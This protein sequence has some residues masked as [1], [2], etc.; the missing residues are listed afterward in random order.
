MSDKVKVLFDDLKDVI[1]ALK[2]PEV[3]T[4]EDY[5]KRWV[6]RN[7]E[8]IKRIKTLSEDELNELDS[9]YQPWFKEMMIEHLNED[10][11]SI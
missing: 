11:N 6:K 4:N 9:L 8:V 5:Q 2:K 3:V 1:L 10:S 7:D